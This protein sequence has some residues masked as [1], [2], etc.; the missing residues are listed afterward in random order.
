MGWHLHQVTQS[1]D[2]KWTCACLGLAAGGAGEAGRDREWL[3]VSFRVDKNLNLDCVMLAQRRRPLRHVEEHA[4][5][6]WRRV[7]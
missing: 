4:F 5:H 3:G 2:R 6:L 1:A 7:L